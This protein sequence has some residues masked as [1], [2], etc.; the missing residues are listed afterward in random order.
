MIKYV[1]CHSVNKKG[2]E[3]SALTVILISAPVVEHC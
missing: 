3:Q 2:A 1:F